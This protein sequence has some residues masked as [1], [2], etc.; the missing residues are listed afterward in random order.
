LWLEMP[1]LFGID[2]V[3]KS[4]SEMD[5]VALMKT[6]Q[7]IV[8]IYQDIKEMDEINDVYATID[9]YYASLGGG[10]ESTCPEQEEAQQVLRD[11]YM[12]A[13][14]DLREYHSHYAIQKMIR[15]LVDR[16]LAIGK[17][18]GY[19]DRLSDSIRKGIKGLTEEEYQSIRE[20]FYSTL[21]YC[22]TQQVIRR[23]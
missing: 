16:A 20:R 3:N 9:R 23:R 21:Y 7:L 11:R 19:D 15:P 17:D 6:K 22:V 5:Y 2:L 12:Y 10:S 1:C 14:H 18:K 8:N 13:H 4:E